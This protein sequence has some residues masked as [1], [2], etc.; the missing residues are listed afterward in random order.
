MSG[1]TNVNAERNYYHVFRDL[2]HITR[3]VF[4]FRLPPLPLR[5]LHF[6]PPYTYIL[7]RIPSF[8]PS[9]PSGASCSS[10]ASSPCR[11][12]RTAWPCSAWR[13][14]CSWWALLVARA[15]DRD[16]GTPCSNRHPRRGCRQARTSEGMGAHCGK[17]SRWGRIVV[18]CM[19]S[20]TGLGPRRNSCETAGV[21][22]RRFPKKGLSVVI[23]SQ[24]RAY[25]CWA[26]NRCTT[27]VTRWRAWLGTQN[28]NPEVYV[29]RMSV[30]SVLFLGDPSNPNPNPR[31]VITA[32]RATFE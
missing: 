31:S 25:G 32:V 21:G 3:V 12:G 29:K 7:S 13:A 23:R 19:L 9:S 28:M 22:G 24:D 1:R 5:A 20:P 26:R 15:R 14:R 6:L 16:T 2:N 8:M 4:L 18:L 11:S 27:R 17:M 30:T 10:C